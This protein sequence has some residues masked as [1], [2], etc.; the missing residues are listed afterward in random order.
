MNDWITSHAL[1]SFAGW[2]N[3]P[4]CTSVTVELL[5]VNPLVGT[6]ISNI[7]SSFTAPDNN[8]NTNKKKN[9]R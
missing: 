8:P 5:M 3:A 9:I 7:P 1:K 2:D 4:D 6:F